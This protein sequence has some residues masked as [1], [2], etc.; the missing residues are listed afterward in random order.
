MVTETLLQHEL[1]TRFILPF[2]LVFF[3]VFGILEKTKLFGDEK[4][5]LNALTA[6]IISLIFVAVTFP[7][8]VVSNM[9]LFLSIA[10]VVMFVGL[11]LW[12]FVTGGEAKIGEKQ[13]TKWTAG[14]VIIVAVVIALFWAAGI[15]GKAIDFLFYQDWSNTLWTNI[16]FIVIV[17]V[18]LAI[19]VK[20]PGK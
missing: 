6:F 10:I 2:L 5:Q 19:A 7:T 15:E 11:L 20:K 18:A 17:A 1:V 14:G 3:I 12:G 4:K 13:W 8:I 9:M 16:A